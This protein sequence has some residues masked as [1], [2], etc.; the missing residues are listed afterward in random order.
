MKYTT[1]DFMDVGWSK[2]DSNQVYTTL[3]TLGKTGA[4]QIH[5]ESRSHRTLW[6]GYVDVSPGTENEV[7]AWLIAFG[8]LVISSPEG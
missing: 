4:V 7:A 5:K 2:E 6:R 3:R 8:A 1:I